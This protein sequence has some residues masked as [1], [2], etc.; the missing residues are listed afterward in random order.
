MSGTTQQLRVNTSAAMLPNRQRPSRLPLTP[1][2][3]R[4][5]DQQ[6][7]QGA[8]LPQSERRVGATPWSAAG[9]RM[10]PRRTPSVPPRGVPGSSSGG[11]SHHGS[12]SMMV[13]APSTNSGAHP[14]QRGARQPPNAQPARA[15]PPGRKPRVWVPLSVSGGGDSPSR[16]GASTAAYSDADAGSTPGGG[17]HDLDGGAGAIP[18]EADAGWVADAGA[19]SDSDSSSAMSSSADIARAYDDSQDEGE[20]GGGDGVGDESGAWDTST[21][22]KPRG[23]R[24]VVVAVADLDRAE[25]RDPVPV[26]GT[27]E[28]V[29]RLQSDLVPMQA[30]IQRLVRSCVCVWLCGCG[31]VGVAVW[32][33]HHHALNA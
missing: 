6:Q 3:V 2:Q 9:Q 19:G 23:L 20:D 12:G 22:W 16:D 32:V 1:A 31:S 4:R 33:C 11:D 18:T 7:G 14:S 5:R 24:P 13:P 8:H 29:E 26:T 25:L 10:P 21:E 27:P 15:Q 17:R 28:V 30:E